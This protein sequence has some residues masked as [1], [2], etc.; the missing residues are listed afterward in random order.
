MDEYR[1]FHNNEHNMY[2][3]KLQI[4]IIIECQFDEHHNRFKM[5]QCFS[6]SYE[7]YNFYRCNITYDLGNTVNRVD[8]TQSTTD[9]HKKSKNNP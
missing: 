3:R 8:V 6:Y 1:I 5:P 9:H 4:I 2:I 7:N